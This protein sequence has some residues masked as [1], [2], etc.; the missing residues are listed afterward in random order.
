[1]KKKTII[2]IASVIVIVLITS[3]II[4]N[5]NKKQGAG[6]DTSKDMKAA[7]KTINKNLGDTLP[8]LE[9]TTI[10]TSDKELVASYTYLSDPSVVKELVVSEPLMSS[11]AYLAIMLRVDD[12]VNVEKIK[13]ELLNN[14]DMNR[15]ICVSA[16]K[17]YVTNSGNTIFAVM[18]FNDWAEPVYEEFKK[19]VGNNIG[20]TLDKEGES[21]DLNMPSLV[22]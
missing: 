14:L 5:N 7:L 4:I 11:Q 2:L 18:S 20:K 22:G 19:Y 3:I 12:N 13:E 6:L 21:G 1:M 16:E 9:V 15:W 10:D 17:L 8:S